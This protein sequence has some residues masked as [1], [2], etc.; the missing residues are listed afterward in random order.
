M[1]THWIYSP[2]ADEIRKKISEKNKGRKQP[3]ERVERRAISLRK[4]G[5]SR[6]SYNFREWRRK[7]LEK[8]DFKCVRCGKSQEKMHCDHIVPWKKD[9]SLR[10]SPENGQV[11]CPACHLKK[12][13]E[14]KEIAKD[15]ITRFKK[16]TPPWNKGKK[17]ISC[18][19]RK[20]LKFSEEHKKKLS[21][22]KIG[23]VPWN[24]GKRK[25]WQQLRQT[26]LMQPQQE[27]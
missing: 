16:G 10:F 25:I 1:K 6:Q 18:G 3:R 5:K 27:S 15:E 13:R 8:C 24:K 2:N 19:W 4:N 12:G 7:V 14:N 21:L 22:A 9:E 17:G 20:G 23:Y 11:L 26:Q